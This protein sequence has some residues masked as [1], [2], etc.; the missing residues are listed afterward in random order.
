M[1]ISMLASREHTVVSLNHL[2]IGRSSLNRF[3]LRRPHI[4][5]ASPSLFNSTDAVKQAASVTTVSCSF[6]YIYFP[7]CI[8]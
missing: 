4:A 7:I 6:V 2:C 1:N 3:S 5:L 8:Y